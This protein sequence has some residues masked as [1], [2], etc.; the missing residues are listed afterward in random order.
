MKPRQPPG[1]TCSCCGGGATTVV[2]LGGG[3]HKEDL[4]TRTQVP[5]KLLIAHFACCRLL[6]RQDRSISP[7]SQLRLPV[8]VAGARLQVSSVF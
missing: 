6:R 1:V 3:G 4:E 2:A 8:L 7:N 5:P